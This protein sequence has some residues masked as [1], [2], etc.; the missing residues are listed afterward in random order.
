LES[1]YQDNAQVNIR[2]DH[3]TYPASVL[4]RDQDDL[5][6]LEVGCLS[7]DQATKFGR[8]FPIASRDPARGDEVLSEGFGGN[9]TELSIHV[10]QVLRT[11]PMLPG[12][13][14]IYSITDFPMTPGESG[15]PTFL[16]PTSK[17]PGWSVFGA[18]HANS[19]LIPSSSFSPNSSLRYRLQ[20]LP[21]GL[22][23]Y[24]ANCIAKSKFQ[25]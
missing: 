18:N 8:N 20:N 15:G 24:N 16:I 11:G 17:E 14:P 1:Y 5:A 25:K 3:G 12:D 10:G 2:T 6:V 19:L 9:G 22:G 4:T 7:H 21:P 13:R 23:Q